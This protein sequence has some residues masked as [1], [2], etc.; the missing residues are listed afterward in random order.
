MPVPAFDASGNALEKLGGVARPGGMAYAS[1][2]ASTAVAST[3]A[4]TLFDTFYTI[5]ANTLKAGSVVK[6]RF[7]GIATTTVANDTLGVKL[8]IG[9]IGG[10]ALITAAATDAANSDTFTGEFQL[11]VRTA[12]TTGTCVGVGTFKVSSAEGTMTIKD[13]ILASTTLNTTTTQVVG[14]AAT[15]NTTNANSCRLDVMS[16]EIYP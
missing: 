9:G 11:H 12:G 2:A 13:D 15:W 16:V 14:V 7:Q 1:V 5:P 8:Y 10:T 6:V 4:E 3:S